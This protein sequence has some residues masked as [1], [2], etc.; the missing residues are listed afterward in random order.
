M[1]SVVVH[2]AVTL[3][4]VSVTGPRWPVAVVDGLVDDAE[5]LTGCTRAAPDVAVARPV[6]VAVERPWRAR[7]VVGTQSA[8]SPKSIALLPEAV[9]A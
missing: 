3:S 9:D 8:L 1:V 6:A 7:L 4:K 2:A 5:A